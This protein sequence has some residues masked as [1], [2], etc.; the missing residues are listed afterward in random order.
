MSEQ[1]LLDLSIR[2]INLNPNSALTGSL[3]LNVRGINK[4]R[5]ATDIDILVTSIQDINF[6]DGMTQ[7]SPQYPDSVQYLLE[8]IK[9]DF[10]VNIDEETEI[11]NGI[12]C[13]MVNKMLDRKYKYSCNDKS[14][15]AREKHRLDLEF[16]NYEFPEID[17]S[18]PF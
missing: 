3:M 1:Q 13:G 4:R 14:V 8:D 9:I 7:N 10:L 6:L 16:M 18:L 12:N 15:E 2:I 11:V 5:E 17:Y